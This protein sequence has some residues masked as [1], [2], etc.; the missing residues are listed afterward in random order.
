MTYN[1]FFHLHIPRTGGTHFQRNMLPALQPIL[2]KNNIG[3]HN[4][5][6]EDTAHWCWFKPLISEKTYIYCS[7]RDPV[8]RLVSQFANQASKAILN[9]NSTYKINDINKN[10]FYAW[11]ENGYEKYKNVQSKSITYYNENHNIYKPSKNI[12]WSPDEY[13]K[14][15]HYMFEDDFIKFQIDKEELYKNF[16]RINLKIK[17]IDLYGEEKQKK[18]L[19]KILNDFKI[20]ETTFKMNNNN[21]STDI[22]LGIINSL[23]NKE[24]EKL[25]QYQDLDSELFFSL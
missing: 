21:Y 19:N 3:V 11:I 16:N 12:V 10:N 7:F 6:E 2:L 20:P 8:E 14:L 9:N 5:K 23:S 13:P 17:S 4:I 22:T 1:L 24:K 15:D 25:Y 18:L